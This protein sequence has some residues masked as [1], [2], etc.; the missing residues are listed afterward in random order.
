MKKYKLAICQFPGGNITKPS[1]P[2]WIL[3]V[4]PDILTDE[5]VDSVIPWRKGDT[6]IDMV[7]NLCVKEVK[8]LGADYILMIDSDMDPDC[9]PGAPGFW[10]TAWKFMMDRRES[11]AKFRD[12]W[13]TDWIEN[14]GAEICDF[15]KELNAKT[16]KAFPPATIAAPYC[17]PPIHEMPYV[18]KWVNFENNTPDPNFN[19]VPFD[20]DQAARFTGISEVA[21]LPT[22]LILYD[23]RVFDALPP[24][25]F[26]Y[27]FSDPP[28]NTRKASTEDV[29]QTRNAA[30]IGMPQYCTWD[31]WA[32]H[33]KEKRVRKPAPYSPTTVPDIIAD[34]IKNRGVRGDYKVQFVAGPDDAKGKPSIMPGYTDQ[35]VK[36]L[37]NVLN[38]RAGEAGKS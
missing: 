12:K 6:P 5:N 16:F 18:F 38:K 25:W 22:G 26:A 10:P 13:A 2:G 21:A 7:R 1:A 27:E 11:E 23:A 20:R 29:Y 14:G 17:G 4:Y 34:A 31:C 28:F 36:Q 37:A 8:E 19:L 32:A 15:D 9:E 35:S 24:P 33:I 3:K 30:L